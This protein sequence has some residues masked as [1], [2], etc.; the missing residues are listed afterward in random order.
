MDSFIKKAHHLQ[1]QPSNEH[2]IT[3]GM[4]TRQGGYSAFPQEAFNMARYVEDDPDN[5]TAHQNILAE[6]IGFAPSQWVFP[7]QTHENHIAKVTSHDQGT[8][9]LSLSHEQLYGIDGLY[10]FDN[11]TLLTMCYADCVPI[12]FYSNKHQFIALAHAGWRGTVKKVVQRILDA[13]P[14]DYDDLQVV[15]GPATSNAYEINEDIFKQFK[16]LP[17][18]FHQYIEPRG[19]DC[20]GIDLKIANQLLCEAYGVPSKNITITQYSTNENTDLFFS[21]RVEKGQTGRMLA[22][23]GQK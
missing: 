9:I 20:Y 8:N 3:I 2:G 4:T 17:I 7:I 22:F 11:N 6:E 5:I 15:I 19:T 1:Y 10:S 21:Y 14:Y 12:Y 23:I 18:D 13:F 16:Q